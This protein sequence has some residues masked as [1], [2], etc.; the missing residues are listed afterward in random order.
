MT[1][2]ELQD[3][4]GGSPDPAGPGTQ[5]PG[6]STIDWDSPDNPYKKRF[7]DYRSEADRKVTEFK[8]YQSYVNDL[9]SDDP[10][11]RA[12]AAEALGVELVEEEPEIYDDPYDE[13]RAEVGGLKEQLSQRDQQRQQEALAGEVERR[14]DK[15]GLSDEPDESGWS[16]KDWVLA[17]AV[18]QPDENGVPDVA[19][20]HA[21]LKKLEAAVE[22][23]WAASKKAPRSIQPGQAATGQKNI[24]EMD[25][26]ERIAYA[27]QKLQDMEA[28]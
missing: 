16:E 10:S 25:D 28:V 17:R 5:D 12:A 3:P 15:L 13:L 22:R 14:L 21:E 27:V 23:K 26:Q 6:A 9:S 11:R 7:E 18:Q 24:L 2:D 20:A 4:L 8:T 1:P 19:V